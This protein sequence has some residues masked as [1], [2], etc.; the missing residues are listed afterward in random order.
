MD[1]TVFIVSSGA[2]IDG[3]PLS[4]GYAGAKRMEWFLADY[5][6]KVSNAKE[7]G[8][9]FVAVLP[10]PIDGSV[11]ALLA[12]SAGSLLSSGPVLSLVPLLSLGPVSPGPELG[13]LSLAPESSPLES[14]A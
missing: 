6:Q 1:S 13:P 4:S 10:R 9:R 2:A 11:K 14:C 3:S 7:L 12:G 8:I 5:A